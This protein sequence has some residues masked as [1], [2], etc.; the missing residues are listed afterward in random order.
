MHTDFVLSTGQIVFMVVVVLASLAVWL[1]A[2]FLATRQ[3]HSTSAATNAGPW[4]Q[5]GVAAAAPHQRGAMPSDK[6]AT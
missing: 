5:D 1:I 3:P 4:E 6:A 2:V